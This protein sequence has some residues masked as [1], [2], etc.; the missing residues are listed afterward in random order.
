MPG[1]YG[2]SGPW[3]SSG[4]T[5]G[6]KP[7]A[8]P[9]RDP[10]GSHT[11]GGRPDNQPSQS[12]QQ[13]QSD[14]HRQLAESLKDAGQVSGNLAF[15]LFKTAP[16]GTTD[17]KVLEYLKNPNVYYSTY[18]KGADAY[19][20]AFQDDLTGYG[21]LVYSDPDNYDPYNRGFFTP[22]NPA[23]YPDEYPGFGGY[24]DPGFSTSQSWYEGGGGGGPGGPGGG[25]Y[26][27]D[28]FTPRGNAPDIWDDPNSL[29]Q[30]MISI[31]GGQGFQQGFRRGGI[32]SLVT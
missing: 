16:V 8:P 13:R 2:R 3:G 1:G 6:S 20:T 24:N 31:H 15:G 25:G 21:G 5:Y 11:G 32:V 7:S 29:Q 22:F 12:D 26:R 14:V 17:P 4:D 28:D 27:E 9:G 30:A 18:G 23:N 19:T 10:G